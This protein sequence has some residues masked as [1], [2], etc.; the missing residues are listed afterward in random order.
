MGQKMLRIRLAPLNLAHGKNDTWD[1]AAWFGTM[2]AQFQT[3]EAIVR[4]RRRIWRWYICTA[5]GD[6]LML[7]SDSSR[8]GARYQANRAL[9]TLLLHSPYRANMTIAPDASD[10]DRLGEAFPSSPTGLAGNSS[11]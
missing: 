10:L 1:G 4:K 5:E 8:T 9:F 7:G 3:F 2:P 6:L 11:K